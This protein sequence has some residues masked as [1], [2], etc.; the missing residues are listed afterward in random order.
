MR[1]STKTMLT[2]KHTIYTMHGIFL[3]DL[4]VLPFGAADMSVVKGKALSQT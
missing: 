4:P 1:E 2:D 3:T